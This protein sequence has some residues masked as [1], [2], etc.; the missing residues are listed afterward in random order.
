M[1]PLLAAAALDY[2]FSFLII[3][4]R[5]GSFLLKFLA[6]PKIGQLDIEISVNQ[7][8]VWLQVS[9]DYAKPM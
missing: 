2:L 5:L 3:C 1:L 7:Y 4:L 9:V 8:I 6:F